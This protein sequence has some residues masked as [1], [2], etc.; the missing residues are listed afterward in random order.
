MNEWFEQ[1]GVQPAVVYTGLAAVL[2]VGAAL[3]WW[4]WLGRDRDIRQLRKVLKP[5]VLDSRENVFVPDEVDGQI[6]IDRLVLTQGGI[7]VLDVRRYEGNLFGGEQINEWTQL[8]GMKR[9]T[10]NNP[11]L[12]MPARLQA[13]KALMPE[14]PVVGRVVFTCLGSF[15][16]GMPE[17]VSMCDTLATDLDAFFASRV[18]AERLHQAWQDLQKHL[19]QAAPSGSQQTL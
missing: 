9:S 2:V 13:V 11:L 16:K 19:E 7:L 14:I 17:G 6:W 4:R 1:L 8:L 5:Y 15:Q 18:E 3:L 10:F 12:S